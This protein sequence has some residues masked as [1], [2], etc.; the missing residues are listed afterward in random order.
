MDLETAGTLWP[1]SPNSTAF[2]PPGRARGLVRRVWLTT[3]ALH[4]LV[5]IL[6]IS[7]AHLASLRGLRARLHT[8]P[9]AQSDLGL[10]RGPRRR[11]AAQPPRLQAHCE[12]LSRRNSN[13]RHDVNLEILVNHPLQGRTLPLTTGLGVGNP[14]DEAHDDSVLFGPELE[15]G[16]VVGN[17]IK[18]QVLL[19][20]YAV[21]GTSLYAGTQAPAP[22][23][24]RR[25]HS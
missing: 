22:I 5:S 9:R 18:K 8:H 15:F 11:R 1:T 7:L 17:H 13:R 19:L 10:L 14:Y 2:G 4:I 12:G 25:A 6:Y 21:G 16:N 3:A 20:K 23:S 24:L